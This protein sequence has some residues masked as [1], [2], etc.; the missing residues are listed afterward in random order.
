M[1]T[2][3]KVE[4]NLLKSYLARI[5]NSIG[6]KMFRNL[7]AK[8]D[9]K[10][11]DILDNG[12]LSC[13]IFVSI[14]LQSFELIKKPH[15]TVIELLKDM[16]ASGWKKSRSLKIGDVLFWEAIDQTGDGSRHLHVGFYLGNNKAI[17]NSTT[18]GHP[19]KHHFTFGTKA[20]KPKRRIIGIYRLN[21]L[22]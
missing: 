20:G 14:I 12:S 3:P 22:T 13:A 15:A 16:E 7:Y 11:R 18:K 10:E 19:V 8:V 6:S 17:S 1:S 5:K 4:V 2:Q 9:G 21:V